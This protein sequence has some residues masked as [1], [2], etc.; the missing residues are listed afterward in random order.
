MGTSSDLSLV[1]RAHLAVAAHIRHTHTSYDSLLRSVPWVEARRR[2]EAQTLDKIVEWRGDDEDDNDVMHDVLREVI[3]IS[4]DEEED[5][6]DFVGPEAYQTN[7]IRQKNPEQQPLNF[8]QDI[9]FIPNPKIYTQP[10]NM[11]HDEMDDL[12][13]TGPIR[14]IRSTQNPF[15]NQSH[16]QGERSNA[17]QRRWQEARQRQRP[18]HQAVVTEQIL[19]IQTD[20]TRIRASDPTHAIVYDSG[21]ALGNG[22]PGTLLADQR[23]GNGSLGAPYFTT[24]GKVSLNKRNDGQMKSRIKR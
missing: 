16:L 24:E 11:S 22:P 19:P 21:R 1:R 8:H 3:V 4:D 17:Y 9:Q 23:Y 20:S 5:D 10:L 18:A 13:A 2:V 15:E 7:T 14:Y 6:D 12:E